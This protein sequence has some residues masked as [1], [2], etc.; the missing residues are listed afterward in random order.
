MENLMHTYPD[1]MRCAHRDSFLCTA[2]A[3]KRSFSATTHTVCVCTNFYPLNA[4][5]FGERLGA[6]V[7]AYSAE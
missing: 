1:L 7:F 5:L 6:N 2:F 4:R 3:L